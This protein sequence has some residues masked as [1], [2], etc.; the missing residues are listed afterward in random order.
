[1]APRPLEL[2]SLIRPN[3]LALQ[4][5]RCARDDYSDGILLDANEN[6]LGHSLAADA[7]AEHLDLDALSLHRYP[8]PA[9][10]AIKRRVVD[11]RGVAESAGGAAAV[12]LG[13][14]SDEII[15]LVMRITCVPG[16]DSILVAPPTYGM[17]SVCA[18]MNDVAIVKIPQ[19]VV[20]GRFSA[21]MRPILDAI[22]SAS[23][24]KLVF[25]TS[26]G[27]PTGSCIPLD[28]VRQLLDHPT[29]RGLVI[30]D[31]AYIDFAP[32]GFS[33]V[34]LINEGY[35]NL[36]I[37]QTLSKGFGL[38][39]IRLGISIAAP[40]L[41]QILTN[42]KAPYNIS[43]PTAALA[44]RALKPESLEIFRGKV[45]TLIENR[46][47]LTEQLATLDGL[48]APLGLPHAN[49]LL[50]PVLARSGKEPD[51]ARAQRI[52]K[53]MAEERGLVVRYRGHEHGCAGCLRIT[54]GTREECEAVVSKL[55][56][57]LEE[58]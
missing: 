42:A 37:M 54:V 7:E 2:K 48:A 21:D 14:G 40:A 20:S 28:D 25:L 17:Y 41:T 1:M 50:V 3:V 36:L 53:T 56:Q 4:P 9:Q 8:D 15:D 43:T 49:F 57:A 26:P 27:N 44:L 46:Q 30:V 51:S 55:R 39:G 32:E 12:F 19:R 11:L 52:Y 35:Q 16:R 10:L 38:A 58:L 5:Y 6:A 45:A 34:S 29:W 22:E 31:E 13:V 33:A 24:P 23:P 18:A 47:W